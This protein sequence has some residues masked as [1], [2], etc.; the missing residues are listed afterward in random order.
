M[1]P[2]PTDTPSQTPT[3]MPFIDP[4]AAMYS[5]I[6]GLDALAEPDNAESLVLDTAPGDELRYLRM[7]MVNGF[8]IEVDIDN[9]SVDMIEGYGIA[10][11]MQDPFNYYL[12][13]IDPVL[14]SWSAFE[15]NP[16]SIP[17]ARAR[18]GA[19]RRS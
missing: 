8:D 12:L 14:Q 2:T 16:W 13:R 15:S 11:R 18:S 4:N 9:D 5:L 17:G 19:A 7:G 10:F 1:T 3:P 6:S